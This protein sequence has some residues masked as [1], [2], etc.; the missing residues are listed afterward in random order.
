MILV[1]RDSG[2]PRAAARAPQPRHESRWCMSRVT[3]RRLPAEPRARARRYVLILLALVLAAALYARRGVPPLW[4]FAVHRDIAAEM[5]REK[6][7]G[8]SV[9]VVAGGNVRWS[10]GYG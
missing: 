8:M 2:R 3:P 10:A 7:P 9:A 6:I 1:G 5:K 4:A